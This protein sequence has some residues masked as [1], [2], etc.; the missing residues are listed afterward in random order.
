MRANDAR[1]TGVERNG[2]PSGGKPA[3]GEMRFKG[4]EVNDMDI[5]MTK[6]SVRGQIVIPQ[7]IR[8]KLGISQGSRLVVYGVGDTIYFK[9]LNL[10]A[11]KKVAGD[12]GA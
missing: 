9:K 10:P 11:P 12:T 7:K 6:V 3:G 2:A 1:R 8:D 5:E 4:K